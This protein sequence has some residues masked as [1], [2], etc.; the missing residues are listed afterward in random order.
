MDTVDGK[1]RS[2]IMAAIGPRHTAPELAVR[3]MLHR[4]GYRF[5]LHRKRL[6]G[7]PDVVLARHGI[8]VFV[9]GCFWHQHSNCVYARMPATNAQ[10][11]REKLLRNIAR[12]RENENAL[13]AV[14]WRVLVI[15]EC[16]VRGRDHS[17]IDRL[18]SRVKAWICSG[19]RKGQF[20]RAISRRTGAHRR[21]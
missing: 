7:R 1:T 8:A 20:P 12:D 5:A 4:M 6:P 2:R 19:R 17:Q 9:H 3:R 14:G 16:A 21:A 11:W 13:L 18:G 10:F 15:W